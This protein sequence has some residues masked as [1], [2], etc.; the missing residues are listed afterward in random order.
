MPYPDVD[1]LRSVGSSISVSGPKA[2]CCISDNE[3]DPI[4]QAMI[5]S[6]QSAS[7]ES[8]IPA[9]TKPATPPNATYGNR[10]AQTTFDRIE[11]EDLM[12]ADLDLLA[13]YDLFIKSRRENSRTMSHTEQHVC[14]NAIR[15]FI[16]EYS[17]SQPLLYRN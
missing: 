10:N 11:F 1:T 17:K 16:I 9:T 3:E 7:A 14:V 13:E 4:G 5:D 2:G 8:P 12:Q 15:L 6:P